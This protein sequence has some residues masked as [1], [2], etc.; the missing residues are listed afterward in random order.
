[1]AL[2]IATLAIGKL[3]IVVLNL[4]LISTFLLT[5]TRLVLVGN[6][7]LAI[8]ALIKTVLDYLLTLLLLLIRDFIV[9]QAIQKA[10]IVVLKR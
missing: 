4:H 3:E 5:L 8:I 9:N 1:M 2:G 10:A 7:N 6:A